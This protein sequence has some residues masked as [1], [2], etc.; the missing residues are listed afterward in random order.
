MHVQRMTGIDHGNGI[1]VNGVGIIPLVGVRH[2]VTLPSTD[3]RLATQQ[4]LF[5][6]IDSEERITHITIHFFATFR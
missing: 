4:S 5:Y 2:V 3:S 6:A 1:A